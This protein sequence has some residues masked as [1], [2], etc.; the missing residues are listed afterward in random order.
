M[1]YLFLTIFSFLPVLFGFLGFFLVFFSQAVYF[2]YGTKDCLVQ[3]CK[4]LNKKVEVSFL[5]WLF[6]GQSVKC[7]N[8]SCEG[9]GEKLCSL[10]C[11]H[12]MISVGGWLWPWSIF[13]FLCYLQL[14]SWNSCL[15]A[16]CKFLTFFLALTQFFECKH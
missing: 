16:Y 5:T 6:S 14:T 11:L 2:F 1:S 10:P 15:W 4:D 9:K 3:E 12:L 7:K 13:V 8:L